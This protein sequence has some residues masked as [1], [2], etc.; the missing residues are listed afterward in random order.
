ML[1]LELKLSD[2]LSEKNN[3][4]FKQKQLEAKGEEID[5][6]KKE[7]INQT[8]KIEVQMKNLYLRAHQSGT[9]RQRAPCPC[10]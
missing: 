7:I 6:Q 1:S 3:L 4:T 2:K 9:R 5:L 10:E 8:K